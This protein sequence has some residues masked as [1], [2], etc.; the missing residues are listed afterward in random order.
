MSAVCA[1]LSVWILFN[2]SINKIVTWRG[3]VLRVWGEYYSIMPA[4]SGFFFRWHKEVSPLS[5]VPHYSGSSPLRSRL[6]PHTT[7]WRQKCLEEPHRTGR[8]VNWNV[9]PILLGNDPSG[10]YIMI[11]R[12]GRN[13][14]VG[15]WERYGKGA[16]QVI[17]LSWG[18]Q[19]HI[20]RYKYI[21]YKYLNRF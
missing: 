13:E 2:T 6:S 21:Y 8:S 11:I 3:T 16:G 1:E 17:E 20:M 12:S 10:P 15:V 5:L 9:S 19:D 4:F 7:E 14:K 18:F